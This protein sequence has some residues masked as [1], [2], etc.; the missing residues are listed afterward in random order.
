MGESWGCWEGLW[1]CWGVLRVLGTGAEKGAQDTWGHRYSQGSPLPCPQGEVPRAGPTAPSAVGSRAP[2]MPTA[3]PQGAPW[4]VPVAT[5]QHW[6]SSTLKPSG[7]LEGTGRWRLL[8][9]T[10]Q[11]MADESTSL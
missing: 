11:I 10:P 8:L 2:R 7:Q 6:R 1:E 9:P 5:H 4:G 3:C